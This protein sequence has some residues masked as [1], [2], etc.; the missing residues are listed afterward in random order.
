M[1]GK[2]IQ[3][4]LYE[5]TPTIDKKAWSDAQRKVDSYV[6]RMQKAWDRIKQPK[7]PKLSE[8]E[9]KLQELAAQREQIQ[10][11]MNTLDMRKVIMKK[12]SVITPSNQI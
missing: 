11:A 7:Q 4:Y 3:E 5:F 8:K 12:H 2:S 9:L 6:G 1:S 10:N